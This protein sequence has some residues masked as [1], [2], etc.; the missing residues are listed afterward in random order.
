M[1][2]KGKARKLTQ[3]KY[4]SPPSS[5]PHILEVSVGLGV[6]ILWQC[7]RNVVFRG[8]ILVGEFGVGGRGIW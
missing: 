8:V 1:R 7:V 6:D 3:S 2:S 5:P 4:F